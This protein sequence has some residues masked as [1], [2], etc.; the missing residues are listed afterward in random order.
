M[1]E[2]YAYSAGKGDCIRLHFAKT[3]NIFIDTGVIRFAPR[4]RQICW[5]ILQSGESLDALILTHVDNDHIGGLLGNLRHHTYRCPFKEVWMNHSGCAFADD[6]PLSVKQ[7]DE[8]YA[9]LMKQ[10]IIVRNMYKGDRREVA[11]AIIDTYW[12]EKAIL[13]K[14]KV[15]MNGDVHLAHH[16]DY[17]IPLSELATIELPVCDTSYNNQLSIICS[18]CFENRSLLF[19]GDAWAKD[20]VKAKGVYDL[21]KLPHHGSARNISNSY[22]DSILS[23]NF[24]ICT[25]GVCHPDKQ[26]IAKL[27]KWYGEINIYSTAGWWAQDFFTGDDASHPIHYSKNGNGG[28][29]IAW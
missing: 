8:V 15:S 21:I 3:H 24:L 27:E 18:I 5:E 14:T 25:D 6:R 10:G 22:K 9:L 16:R 20:V 19:T 4:F 1:L 28:L 2:V 26:T 29:I 13:T 12:P 17:Q 23:L 7:N 11:G